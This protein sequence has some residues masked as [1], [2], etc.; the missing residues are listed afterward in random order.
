MC[1]IMKEFPLQNTVYPHSSKYLQKSEI[2]T[3]LQTNDDEQTMT[4]FP[5]LSEPSLQTKNDV[6]AP[7]ISELLHCSQWH[8]A[9]S[10]MPG[11]CWDPCVLFGFCWRRSNWVPEAALL[12]FVALLTLST[13]PSISTASAPFSL[14]WVHPLSEAHYRDTNSLDCIY[15]WLCMCVCVVHASHRVRGQLK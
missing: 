9:G 11:A 2:H 14:I 15:M 1:K 12:L 4:A 13:P 5:F 7:F 3:A 8:L 10:Q 6:F